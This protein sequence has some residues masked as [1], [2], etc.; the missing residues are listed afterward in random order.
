LSV[1]NTSIANPNNSIGAVNN[2]PFNKM[3]TFW[4]T[5]RDYVPAKDKAAVVA[6]F[7]DKWELSRTPTLIRLKSSS[8]KFLLSDLKDLHSK[9]SIA[10][11]LED[12]FFIDHEHR[13]AVAK[14]KELY[15]LSK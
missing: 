5:W 13:M 7:M 11:S 3:Q 9:L 1:L 15:G 8:F 4:E 14:T 2:K 10:Y 12:G 6:Y